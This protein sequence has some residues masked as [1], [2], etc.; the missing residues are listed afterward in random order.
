MPVGVLRI[1][2]K[3]MSILIRRLA[4]LVHWDNHISGSELKIAVGLCTTG[5]IN[6]ASDEHLNCMRRSKLVLTLYAR[7][8]MI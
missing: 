1:L 6:K 3:V 2:I 5:F 4:C 8:N 7:A